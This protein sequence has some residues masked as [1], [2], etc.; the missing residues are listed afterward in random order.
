MIKLSY[1]EID[2]RLTSLET[3]Y[4]ALARRMA[5]IESRFAS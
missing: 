3:A 2:R 5:L 1:A 4:E